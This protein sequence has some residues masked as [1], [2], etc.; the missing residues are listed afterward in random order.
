[1]DALV[2]VIVTFSMSVV[3]SVSFLVTAYAIK[4]INIP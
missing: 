3:V 4:I 1:M 2:I